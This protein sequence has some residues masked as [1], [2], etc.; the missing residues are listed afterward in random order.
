MGFW[1]LD[2]IKSVCGGTWLARPEA[3]ERVAPSGLSTDSRT[4]RAGEAFL[5]LRGEAFDGHAFIAEAGRKGAVLA[6]VDREEPLREA[7]PGLPRTFAALL[8]PDAGAALLKLAGAYRKTLE[9]TKVVAVAGSNGKTTTTR[10]IEGVL[11]RAMRGS[12]SPKSFNNAVGV[13]LTVLRAKRGDQYLVCEVGTNAPGEIATLG[14][15]LQ[16]DV[17]VITSLGREHLEGLGSLEGVAR[18]EASLLD[19]VRGGGA[20]IVTADAD[21]AAQKILDEK[22]RGGHR[23]V[24]RFGFADDADLRITAC[25]GTASGTRMCLNGRSW[26]EVP[27]LGRHNA[28]NATAAIAVAKRLGVD[29]GAIVDGLANAAG[30]PMRLERSAAAGV[31]FLNDA[32]NANPE[33]VLA[34]LRAFAEFRPASG[35]GLVRGRRVVVLGDMLELGEASEGAHREIGEAVGVGGEVDVA[36]FV[37]PMS[38][39]GAGAARAA[40]R[41]PEVLHVAEHDAA[42][43]RR[44]ASMLGPGDLVLL[45]GSRRVALERVVEVVRERE[46]VPIPAGVHAGFKAAASA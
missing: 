40:R 3:S 25:E 18:E 28:S 45:K 23:T 9:S 31:E 7:L 22:A 15:V 4:I 1:D 29:P 26:Y 12:A 24:V 5:A 32:Y 38:A 30:P 41:V 35:T 42:G 43:V 11:S 20:A 21:P 27:L 2:H 33:S 17:A 14:K 13:P 34:A 39:V 19:S 6:I 8:V 36:I 16:P 44:V 46:R 10:L 37:G